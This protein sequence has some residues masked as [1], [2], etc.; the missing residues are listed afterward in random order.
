MFREFI[1]P[2]I[3]NAFLSSL[4]FFIFPLQLGGLSYE[5][6][7]FWH[8][9]HNSSVF[10][11]FTPWSSTAGN[12]TLLAQ[13][14]NW[15]SRLTFRGPVRLHQTQQVAGSWDN[16]TP[17]SARCVGDSSFRND[18][19]TE[20]YFFFS[21]LCCTA[22][23]CWQTTHHGQDLQVPWGR[24]HEIIVRSG[25]K[26]KEMPCRRKAA[27]KGKREGQK[28]LNTRE[29]QDDNGPQQAS[30]FKIQSIQQVDF[31]QNKWLEIHCLK[32]SVILGFVI[33][34]HI[35]DRSFSVELLKF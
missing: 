13:Q 17:I 20:T 14:S 1:A 18:H 24:A 5:S 35:R 2:L 4:I 28:S 8:Q 15:C 11:F 34:W 27:I 26:V 16:C 9:L 21:L 10:L 7:L 19:V 12:S 23:T 22:A 30:G 29:E 32:G 33:S 31:P 25:E 3:V 6:P